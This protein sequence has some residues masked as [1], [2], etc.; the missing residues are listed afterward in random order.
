M[1][2]R[3]SLKMGV[4][5][6]G[7]VIVIGVIVVLWFIFSISQ[8]PIWVGTTQNPGWKA[9]YDVEFVS[10]ETWGRTYLLARQRNT[11]PYLYTIHG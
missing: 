11:N 4:S 8:P 3:L 1:E 6:K 5:W 10:Q 9:I 7:V 2:G